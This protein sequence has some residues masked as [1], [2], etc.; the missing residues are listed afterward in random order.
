[1]S[2]PPPDDTP[3]ASHT[4]TAWL[5][6]GGEGP[7]T[8]LALHWK[9]TLEV[10]SNLQY[11]PLKDARVNIMTH[12]FMYGTATFEGIRGYWNAQ[13][14]QLHVRGQ[15]I[16]AEREDAACPHRQL[17]AADDARRHQLCR[18]RR[19][20]SGCGNSIVRS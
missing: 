19:G 13:Q 2:A 1:M 16:D 17:H 12:A 3:S 15:V 9:D 4:V 7:R 6:A 10:E 20:T 11:V 14:H 5:L 18:Q 8:G